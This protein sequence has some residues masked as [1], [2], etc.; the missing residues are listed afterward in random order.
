MKEKGFTLIELLAVIVILAIIA[1]IA[2]P[3][4]LNII[5]DAREESNKRSIEMYANAIRN[6]IAK[7][8]LNGS[9]TIEGTFTNTNLPFE[10]E[11]DGNV[12]CSEIDIYED[13]N[14]YLANCTVNGDLVEG[15]EYG[16]KQELGTAKL[17]TANTTKAKALVWSGD[18]SS[19]EESSYAEEEVGLLARIDGA[20]TT[21]VA[22]TCNFIDDSEENN[23]TFFVLSSTETEVTLISGSNLSGTVTSWCGDESQC[24]TD[25]KWDNTK[26]PITANQALADRTSNWSTKNG[27]KL[28]DT[29]MSSIKL[30][31]HDQIA[32]A[33]EEGTMP[34]WLHGD[35]V[36]KAYWTSSPDTSTTAGAWFVEYGGGYLSDLIGY[37]GGS[38]FG[39]RP[40]ITISI[41]DLN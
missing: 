18:G 9:D 4:I 10:V 28:N 33:Y 19:F 8:Y 7:E 15:Y 41:S 22:Y 6:T 5:D 20:Y 36:G 17:C 38:Y 26:G 31:T 3:I 21:G 25:G 40:V 12:E 39:V 23:L 14:I 30:P 16:T 37:D 27:G 34:T 1:L 29:Q 11:Y 13:G 2:T 35:L 32:G 24:K